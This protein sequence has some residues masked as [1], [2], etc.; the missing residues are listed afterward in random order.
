[1]SL[2]SLLALPFALKIKKGIDRWAA[3]P[4][5]TQERVFQE[6]I[7]TARLT[8]FGVDH[9]FVSINNHNDFVKHVP[10]RDYEQLK[11]YVDKVVAGKE[12]ILWPKKPLNIAKK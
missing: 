7:S 9:D 2:K 3:N 10:V 4:I 5:A 12:N 6:L 1:M 8:E 11:H